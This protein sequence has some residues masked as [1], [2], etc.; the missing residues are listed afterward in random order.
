MSL[1]RWL[2][3]WN[4]FWFPTTTT[5]ALG[6]CRMVAVAAQLF[7][8]FPKLS[9]HLNLVEKN[10]A[11]IQPQAL[12]MALTAVVPRDLLFSE[13][14][15]RSLYVVTMVAGVLA[16]VG[17][18]TRTALLVLAAGIWIFVAHLYS[19]GGVHHEAALFSILLVCLACSPSGD[20]FSLD[21][22]IRDRRGDG[23]PR[24]VDTASWAL[25]LAHVLLAMTYFST[26][27]T[28]VIDGGP[29]WING[30]TLQGYL[31]GDAIARGLPLGIWLARQHE[32]CVVL[33]VYTLLFELF[34]FVSLLVPWTAPLFFIS[35]IGFHISLYLTGGHDFFPHIVTL[36]MLLIATVPR[37][38]E[39][40]Q[41]AIAAATAGLR[42][43]RAT[44][45]A[46]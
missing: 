16:L 13:T 28:K 33:S 39:E 10:S 41:G 7:W 17:W 43:R 4:A 40:R 46:A 1:A 18:W 36:V 27:M 35:G 32:L 29:N 31:F 37:W 14:G 26:G 6:L 5:R 22:L 19:Y 44:L 11:F 21:A 34:F 38:W 25:R 30:Y 3:R 45:P 2:T 23:G 12:I 24:V 15:L 20:S 8:F 9:E 42:R